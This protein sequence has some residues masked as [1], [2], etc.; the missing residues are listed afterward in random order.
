[1]FSW[2]DYLAQ[3]PVAHAVLAFSLVVAL[4]LALG[5]LGISRKHDRSARVSVRHQLHEIGSPP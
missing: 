4:G 2:V 1:M 5:S 3:G